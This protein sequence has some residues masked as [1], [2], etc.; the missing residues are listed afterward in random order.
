M[1]TGRS[2]NI[3][4]TW[5]LYTPRSPGLADRHRDQRADTAALDLLA[6]ALEQLAQPAGDDRQHDVVDGARRGAE[7]IALTSLRWT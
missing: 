2:A 5:L 7:R 4:E 3:A 1:P 6:A